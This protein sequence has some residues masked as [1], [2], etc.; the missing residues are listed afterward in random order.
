LFYVEFWA[1]RIEMASP[2]SCEKHYARLLQRPAVR[3][4]LMEEGYHSTLNRQ[5]RAEKG[6]EDTTARFI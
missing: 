2:D 1:V 4:V 5:P 3:R 6:T